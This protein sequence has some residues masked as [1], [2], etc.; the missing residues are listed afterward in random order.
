MILGEKEKKGFWR[1]RRGGVAGDLMPISE[2]TMRPLVFHYCVVASAT[3]QRCHSGSQRTRR[4]EF[5]WGGAA[6]RLQ[7]PGAQG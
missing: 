1:D 3:R 2:G 7:R 4:P 5:Q 6:F